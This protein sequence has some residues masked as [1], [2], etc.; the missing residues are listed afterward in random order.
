[1]EESI[2]LDTAV[3]DRRWTVTTLPSTSKGQNI[4]AGSSLW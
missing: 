2:V 1:M 3:E 4:E